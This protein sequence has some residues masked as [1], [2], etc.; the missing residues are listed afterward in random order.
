LWPI[1]ASDI[2]TNGNFGQT[3]SEDLTGK[4]DHL[5]IFTRGSKGNHNHDDNQMP[6]TCIAIA[7]STRA[8]IE[9]SARTLGVSATAFDADLGSLVLAARL[10][11]SHLN[12][13]PTTHITIL[14]P[15]PSAIQAI[16]NLRPHSGWILLN[17]DSDFLSFQ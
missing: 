14:S 16:T 5:T 10:A 13:S 4:P 8:E 11:Q 7:F 17:A 9:H 2:A 12:R 3:Q 1:T 15:I 6:A